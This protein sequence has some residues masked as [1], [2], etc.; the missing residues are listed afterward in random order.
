MNDPKAFDDLVAVPMSSELCGEAIPVAMQLDPDRG[1]AKVAELLQSRDQ[2]KRNF[3]RYMLDRFPVGDR[4]TDRPR[5]IHKLLI[6]SSKSGFPDVR[7][8]AYMW[9]REKHLGNFDYAEDTMAARM[10]GLRDPDTHARA[11]AAAS[12]Y[13]LTDQPTVDRLKALAADTTQPTDVRAA[14]KQVLDNL[15][16]NRRAG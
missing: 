10:R 2:N 16:K 3:G 6:E 7:A 8:N 4:N 1:I 13:G 9:L 11:A 15:K 5:R 12:C 14:A